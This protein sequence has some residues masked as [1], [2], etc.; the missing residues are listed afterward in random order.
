VV[1]VI[2]AQANGRVIGRSNDL[3]W[4]LPADLKHFKDLTTGHSVIMGRKTFESILARLGKPLPNRTNIVITRDPKFASEGAV[5]VRSPDEALA[6][7][8]LGEMFVIGG[9]SI[10][11]A[12]LSAVDRVYLTQVQADIAG[13]AYFPAL[14][15]AEWKEL[16]RTSFD[17]DEKNQYSYE[18]ITLERVKHDR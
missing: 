13:D 8:G 2:V 15:P 16:E 18:F 3:P 10:Y 7:A 12:M 4:Y 14:D 17:A 5:V 11:E 6:R 9:A 1:S